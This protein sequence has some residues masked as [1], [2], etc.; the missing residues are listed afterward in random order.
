MSRLVALVAVLEDVLLFVTPAVL[1]FF[2]L[3]L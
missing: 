1:A 2:V 3:F